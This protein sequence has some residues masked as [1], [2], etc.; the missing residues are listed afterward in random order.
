MHVTC[1]ACAFRQRGDIAFILVSR[2]DCL[3]A[4][5]HHANGCQT[6]TLPERYNDGGNNAYFEN[7]RQYQ[8][9]LRHHVGD[10]RHGCSCVDGTESVFR[11]HNAIW[12]W[13]IPAAPCMHF[14]SGEQ[15]SI[16]HG[17]CHQR[18]SQKTDDQR[19]NNEGF[20]VFGIAVDDHRIQ[21]EQ[22]QN[23]GAQQARAEYEMRQGPCHAEQ[24][25]GLRPPSTD[26]QWNK[27]C[28]FPCHLRG[29]L[30]VKQQSRIIG[31]AAGHA[32]QQNTYDKRD[33][34]IAC[35][36]MTMHPRQET[37]LEIRHTFH[38]SARY[39]V[40]PSCAGMK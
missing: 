7:R 31:D 29:R 25:S 5:P 11:D 38:P 27:H 26:Q 33:D 19:Q 14:A 32:E 20:R 22:C 28:R 12:I 9:V 2:G 4:F 6:G 15:W 8:H 24:R 23:I 34:E 36:D 10:F 30:K 17:P 13:V 37:L 1:D 40:T 21:H 35:E 39:A 3:I 18:R 16:G